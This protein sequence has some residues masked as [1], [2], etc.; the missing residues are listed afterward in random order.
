[1][2]HVAVSAAYAR[3]GRSS[4]AYV[5]H[6]RSL[7]SARLRRDPSRLETRRPETRPAQHSAAPNPNL[8]SGSGGPAEMDAY[9]LNR[10]REPKTSL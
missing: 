6:V 4:L 10:S 3:P 5:R 2:A 1:M 8:M 7:A 9:R